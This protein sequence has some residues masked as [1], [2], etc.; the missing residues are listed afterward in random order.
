MRQPALEPDLKRMIIG[1]R[2]VVRHADELE[3]RIRIHKV[4]DA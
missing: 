1:C 4:S 2:R 3:I